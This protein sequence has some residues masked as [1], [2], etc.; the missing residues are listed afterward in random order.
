MLQRSVRQVLAVAVA[1]SIFTGMSVAPVAASD[2]LG[3]G[4]DE[5]ISIGTDGISI[6]GDEGVGIGA[7]AD[8]G[9]NVSAGGEE[10]LEVGASPD[11]GVSVGAAGEE[12]SVG[13]DGVDAPGAGDSGLAPSGDS[14]LAP[15]GEDSGVSGLGDLAPGGESSGESGLDELSSGVESLASGDSGV[16]SVGGGLGD[17]GNGSSMDPTDFEAD[18]D[19]LPARPL[20]RILQSIPETDQVGPE[21]S[22]IGDESA[23]FNICEALTVE[24]D[25]LPLGSLPGLGALPDSLQ[26]PGLPAS[27]VTPESVFGILFGFIPAP[28]DV[29]NPSDP[30]IDP[31]DL[32]DDPGGEF[33]VARFG[34]QDGGGVGLAY[35]EGSL[36]ESGEG[37]GISGHTGGLIT[38]EYGDIDQELVIN[39]GKN[40]YGVD[41]R[42]RYNNDSFQ[43]E[44]VLMFLGKQAGVEGSCDDLTEYQPDVSVQTLQENPLGPCEYQLVGLPNLLG[45]SDVFGILLGLADSGDGLPVNPDGLPINPDALLD[46]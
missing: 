45:P 44:A 7:S 18:T 37:P 3:L 29:F 14:G 2:G 31:T 8:D 41:P 38:Q 36:N 43:G 16:D 33:D 5:G 13:P 23:Q 21:D 1:V 32:P 40:D 4:G 10:G 17:L 11:D 27:L 34:Q 12:A 19:D 9:V 46:L 42:F 26:P 24:A 30:Q 22:P 20:E 28:C 35:Y 25:D 15:S 39:D 6:G